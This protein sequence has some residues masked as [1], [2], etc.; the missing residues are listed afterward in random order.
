[1]KQSAD[2]A[3]IAELVRRYQMLEECMKTMARQ[4]R[5]R[6]QLEEKITHLGLDN[7]LV[8]NKAELLEEWREDKG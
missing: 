5:R 1:V 2:Q 4:A 7:N 3:N 8:K 6:T